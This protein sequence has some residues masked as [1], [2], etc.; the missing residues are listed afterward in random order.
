MERIHRLQ[1]DH[2]HIFGLLSL[3]LAEMLALQAR[4]QSAAAMVRIADLGQICDLFDRIT[5]G[6]V[7]IQELAGPEL[8]HAYHR[9]FNRFTYVVR[10]LSND[11]WSPY[12]R[13]ALAEMIVGLRRD[14]KAHQRTPTVKPTQP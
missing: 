14:L 1:V 8:R 4:L 13:N 3:I 6:P 9:S 10:Y 2:D 11:R 12:A 7:P 5:Q